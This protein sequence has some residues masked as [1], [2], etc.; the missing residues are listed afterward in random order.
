MYTEKPIKEYLNEL[1]SRSPV[2]GGG[3]ASAL[4]GAIGAALISK[5]ANFTIGKEK[6][7]AQEPEMKKILDTAE[8]VRTDL[9]KLC[10]ED[11]VCYGKLSEAY[12]S[13]K[14][15]LRTSKIEIALKEAMEVPRKI[16]K[17]A[18]EAIKLCVPLV[19]KG[20]IN[21]ITDVGDAALVLE[22]AFK[23]ALLNVE[24]NIKYMKD[25]RLASEVFKELD[26]MKREAVSIC[27]DVMN[28]VERGT[29]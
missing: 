29:R 14:T 4:A 19:E 2:P 3:S 27:K 20:N 21:L 9:E 11:A 18:H 26:P 7:K 12:K 22:S 15:D 5:V 28:K 16:C 17:N 1:A 6:Y 10:S 23:S 25:K 13:P 8:R 24:I